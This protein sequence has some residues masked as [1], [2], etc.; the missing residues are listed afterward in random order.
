MGFDLYWASV[1]LAVFIGLFALD[2]MGVF[3]RKNYFELD[4]KTVLLTGG[5]AGMGRGVAKILAQK[6]ANIV[7]VARNQGRLSE[8]IAYAS[9]AA[10][11]PSKQRFH[12]ISADVTSPEENDRIV[13]ETTAWNHGQPP[14][15]VWQVAGGAHPALFRD[16]PVDVL[17]N[18]MDMN[19]WG[20]AYLAQTTLKAW[21]KPSSKPDSSSSGGKGPRQFV[22]TSSVAALLGA[23]GYAPYCPAKA[24]MRSLADTLHSEVN[25]YNGSRRSKDATVRAEA[26]ERDISIHL[27]M[28]GTISSPGLENENKTKHAVTT[29]LEKDDTVQTEDEVAA[30]AVRGLEKGGYIVTTQFIASLLRAGMLGGSA[31]NNW[32]LDTVMSWVISIVWLFIKPDMDGKVFNYGKK[33]GTRNVPE[34][35]Q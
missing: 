31:R 23:A 18:Q 25:I 14:D 27:V 13:S 30:A 12:T 19:Y 34:A 4:G 2:I 24:A 28:P 35:A 15:I 20:A 10:A 21:T 16:T 7:I 1:G 32:F 29:I 3:N 11:N 6:G 5:S 22:M 9:A 17:R 8:A 33:Y 26:P